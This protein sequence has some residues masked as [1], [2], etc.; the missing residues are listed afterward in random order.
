MT[1]HGGDEDLGRQPQV[2][3]LEAAARHA[4]PLGEVDRLGQHVARVG[5]LAAELRGGGVE[6]GGDAA[7]ALGLRD[8]DLLVL[9][10]ALV[11]AGVRDRDRRAEHAVPLGHVA[12]RQAVE[13][14]AQGLVAQLGDQPADGAREAQVVARALR[15]GAPAHAARD[16]QAGDEARDQ[17]GHD[18]ARRAPA[19]LDADDH[20]LRAVDHLAPDVLR[21]RALGA[22]EPGAGL[23]QRAV[24]GVRDLGLGAAELLHLGE[25][26]VR[27]AVDQDGDA[28]RR[29]QDPGRRALLQQALL[30]EQRQREAGLLRRALQLPD[31]R[32]AHLVRQ[33][34]GADLD[35]QRAHAPRPPRRSR[36]RLAPV[37]DDL[38][39]EAGD[40]AREVA[41]AG[42]VRGAVGDADHAARVEH[43]EG[44]AALEHVVVGRDGQARLDGAQ[45][46]GLVLAEVAVQH[47]GVRHLEVVGA[48]LA[49]VL[50]VDVAVGDD[51]LGAVLLP[52]RPHEVVDAV[53]ALQV[54]GEPLEA[55]GD[56]DGDGVE[57][58]AAELLEVGELGGLH[59][60]DPDLPA[61]APGA[62]RGALPVVLDEAHVVLGED[63]AEGLERAQVHVL[64]VG[65]GRLDDHLVLVVVAQ[66]V[67]VLAVAAV[68]G[69]H[70]RLD[71]GG[72]PG[73]G[74]EAAQERRGVEG[75]GADLGVVRL[76]DD[77]ALPL[78]EGL[79]A[80][81]D[82]LERGGY[83]VCGLG[84]VGHVSFRSEA[85]FYQ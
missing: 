6:A 30:A 41:H 25:L 9:E 56:L 84:V 51:V 58:E 73:T 23:G 42:D 62:E 20:E 69:A 18:V 50:L 57:V 43:V 3:L 17:L 12:E 52:A 64:D 72:A 7:A 28:A 2:P 31:H 35:Q 55:V 63:D 80:A 54:H 10:Q 71:V 13:L 5:P 61:L 1:L 45:R 44:V 27:H 24:R 29:H 67:G 82:L 77:A 74:V 37:A 68:G 16:L 33:L 76:D 53:H 26:L 47:L 11:V 32:L 65:R 85:R 70:G 4:R 66:A 39:V 46:L 14:A 19:G 22:R 60:V 59:A 49:L 48:E 36:R 75:A 78:P 8:D 15:H 81:D 40:L 21:R 83:G 38:Q 79:Q 34:L